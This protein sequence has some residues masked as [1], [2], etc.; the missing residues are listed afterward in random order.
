MAAS[1]S[2]SARTDRRRAFAI[3]G[4]VAVVLTIW[5]HRAWHA[6]ALSLPE[7]LAFV[8]VAPLETACATVFN[9]VHDL[10]VGL[11]G[12]SR[13]VEENR[14]LKAN[15]DLL[16]AERML[17][18]DIRLENKALREK[19]GLSLE[20]PFDRVAAVVISRSSGRESRW[21]KIRAA[22]GKRLEVGNV[23]RQE[24][25]LAGRITEAYGDVAQVVLLVDPQHAVRGRDLRTGEEGMV[26]A[27]SELVAGPNRLRFERTRRGAQ[28]AVGDIIVTSELGETYPGRIPIGVVESV[29]ASASNVSGLVA[30]IKP[31]VDFDRLDYVYVL[32]S[33]QS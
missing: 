1:F 20:K 10:G 7:Y 6:Q 14:R 24:R 2:V 4:V 12:A 33:G 18:V 25:G 21:V 28:I 29:R 16:S 15:C 5:Q 13:L 26:Y 3:M 31:Y 22:G 17:N 8:L 9:K 11:A 19:L 32:R 30:Y 23:V 27:A